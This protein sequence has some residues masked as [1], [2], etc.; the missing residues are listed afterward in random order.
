[1]KDQHFFRRSVMTLLVMGVLAPLFVWGT[2]QGA[3]HM[4][5]SP[6]RWIPES[7]EERQNYK[8]FADHFQTPEYIIISWQ[9]CTVED[10]RLPQLADALTDPENVQ[11]SELVHD[12]TT[13]YAAMQDLTSP[14]MSLSRANAAKRLRGTLVGPDGKTSC[15]VI[16]L[17]EEGTVKSKVALKLVLTTVRNLLGVPPN[18]CFL[19]GSPID[20][21]AID[22]ASSKAISMYMLPSTIVVLLLS[23]WCLRSWPLTLA[24]ILT[25]LFGQAL[26][27]GIVFFVGITMNAVL[28]VMAPL[29]Y[30]LTVSAGVHLVNY[31]HDEVRLRGPHGAARRAL[32]NG[33]SPCVLAAVTTAVGLVSLMI[34]EMI[35]VR[36]FGIFASTTLLATTGL[37]FL[38]LPGTM[39]R[40]PAA[41]TAT[42]DTTSSPTPVWDRF[43]SLIF[44]F[45]PLITLAC[46]AW[47]I[48]SFVGL[49]RLD[50]SVKVLSMLVPNSRT[51]RDYHWLEKNV[52]PMVPIEIV[53]KFNPEC[54]LNMLQRLEVVRWAQ[55][56]LGRSKQIDGTLSAA[57]FFPAIPNSGG[58]RR[59][60]ARRVLRNQLNQQQESLRE[61]HYL[62]GEKGAEQSWRI[63][64]RAPALGD[65]DYGLFLNEL[66][67]QID[68]VLA[69]YNALEGPGRIS[70]KYTGIMP[71]VYNVQRSMLSDLISSYL[72]ALAMVGVIMMV[73]LRSIGAGLVA[74]L[75]NMFPT[76]VLFGAMGWSGTPIDIGSMMTASVALGIAVDGTLHFL[77]W[78]R[79]ELDAGHSRQESVALSFRHCAR[80]IAQT[81]FI[82]GLGLLVYALSDFVPTRRFAFMM[83]ALLVAACVGD[84]ILLPAL[85]VSPLGKLF[86]RR[87][88]PGSTDNGT[89]KSGDV[90][91]A[92]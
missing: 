1:M 59:T 36:Y 22:K 88:K 50:S 67:K 72:A 21:V 38:V 51:V 42:H 18:D 2:F 20:G 60:A 47:M 12:V 45:S 6:I 46:A 87:R 49:W 83:F 77:N 8:W 27:L 28:T 68:P 71:L 10:E 4:R 44:R 3:C 73:V 25:A 5:N 76:F 82:C 79:R 7:F 9:G 15:A 62:Q 92:A 48:V 74:M 34:S 26:V 57:S 53:L 64:A 65:L 11:A 56:E 19:A 30:V 66:R 16:G 35:P 61:A 63:S 14:P 75:P 29:V 52:G 37:L 89:D 39:V 80:A 54:P 17:T 55:R 31:Y 70:A 90:N 41:T 13:G 23:R 33:W 24:V 32:T 84:L 81:T 78:F 85:L 69:K 58:V 43:A 91:Q 86:V 40:W